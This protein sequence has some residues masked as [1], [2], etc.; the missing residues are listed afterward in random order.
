MPDLTHKP[1]RIPTVAAHHVVAAD[2]VRQL[3]EYNAREGYEFDKIEPTNPLIVM[4]GS[5][6]SYT[7]RPGVY[8]WY[9]VKITGPQYY[10][11]EGWMAQHPRHGFTYA[12]HLDGEDL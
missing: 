10:V 4:D 9:R 1:E 6:L 5:A 7:G 11:E 8:S 2:L 3:Q 12:E